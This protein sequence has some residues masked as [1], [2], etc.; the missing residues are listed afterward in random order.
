MAPQY[1]LLEDY[2]WLYLKHYLEYVVICLNF[3]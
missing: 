2:L 3:C 1:S